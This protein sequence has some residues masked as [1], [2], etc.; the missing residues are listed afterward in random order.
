MLLQ[1]RSMKWVCPDCHMHAKD[2]L[3]TLKA[4]GTKVE[5]EVM[6]NFSLNYKATKEAFSESSSGSNLNHSSQ[7]DKKSRDNAGHH[8]ISNHTI[9]QGT[10]SQNSD[11]TW[12]GALVGILIPFL[13]LFIYNTMSS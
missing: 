3:P 13:A 5:H 8:T 2:A 9:S 11:S 10:K 6:P 7:E 1:C 12:I 4:E